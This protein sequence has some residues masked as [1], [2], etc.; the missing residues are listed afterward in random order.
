MKVVINAIPSSGF[1]GAFL[2]FILASI[3]GDELRTYR[4]PIVAPIT[5]SSM[6]ALVTGHEVVAALL[7]L[8][9]RND[10]KGPNKPVGTGTL[11]T[12]RL[13]SGVTS[14]GYIQD[15]RRIVITHLD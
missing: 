9:E 14:G 13:I 11:Q 6:T 4:F 3:I 2:G 8:V 1:M 15:T 5:A 7:L 10:T 12:S